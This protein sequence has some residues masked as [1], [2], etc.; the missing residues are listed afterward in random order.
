MRA[1][2]IVGLAGVSGNGQ[3][4]LAQC[5]AG[6]RPVTAGTIIINGQD[7]THA[8][9]HA[10]MEAG[11]AYIPEERMRDGAIREFSV[12]E[13]VF[14]HEHASP[15]FT[16]GIFLDFGKMAAHARDTGQRV[17][18]QNPRPRHAD[19][20]PLGRQHPEADHGARALAADPRS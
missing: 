3:R 15:K 10:R 7:M 2:E 6:L 11:Q 9:L 8:P 13:N 12:Q 20:E 17:R 18:G 5:L 4:E 19:Q 14:L 1:G 16:R